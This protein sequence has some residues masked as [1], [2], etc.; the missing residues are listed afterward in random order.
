[1]AKMNMQI[2]LFCHFYQLKHEKIVNY[3]CCFAG[4]FR[5]PGGITIQFENCKLSEMPL[6]TAGNMV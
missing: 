1:M 4:E 3:F 2:L 6:Q 5:R